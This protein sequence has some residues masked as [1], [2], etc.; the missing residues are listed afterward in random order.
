M[1]EIAILKRS[2]RRCEHPPPSSSAVIGK[3]AQLALRRGTPNALKA[4][5]IPVIRAKNNAVSRE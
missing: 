4:D 1:T 5:S 2:P 3:K